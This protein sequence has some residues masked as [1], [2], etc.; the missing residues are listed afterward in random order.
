MA[1]ENIKKTLS[2]SWKKSVFWQILW[3]E[4]C[5]LPTKGKKS[6]YTDKISMS[7]RSAIAC[8][9][10]FKESKEINF[11]SPCWDQPVWT[12]D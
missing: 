5:I 8:K 9:S 12:L 11:I 3:K 1:E 2:H 6:A 10:K 4:I 7:G